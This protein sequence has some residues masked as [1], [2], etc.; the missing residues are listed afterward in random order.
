MIIDFVD[1]GHRPCRRSKI[2]DRLRK[3]LNISDDSPEAQ[4]QQQAQMAQ[5][6]AIQQQQ[7]ALDM[8]EK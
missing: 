8:R 5:Q 1:R 4:Q 6:Q 7:L 3:G 2:A